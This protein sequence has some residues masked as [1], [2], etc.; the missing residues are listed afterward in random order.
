MI[1]EKDYWIQEIP[2]GIPKKV[3]LAIYEKLLNKKVGGKNIFQTCKAPPTIESI[4]FLQSEI[5]LL[6]AELKGKEKLII[7]LESEIEKLEAKPAKPTR[8]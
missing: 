8:K 6:R 4:K 3:N 5:D 2:N 1:S 7:G